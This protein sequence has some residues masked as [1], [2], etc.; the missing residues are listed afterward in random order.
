MDYGKSE[1]IER[2]CSELKEAMERHLCDGFNLYCARDYKN[3][4]L[5][6]R[7]LGYRGKDKVCFKVIIE[8][9]R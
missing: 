6:I 7:D 4:V 5:V 3:G 1:V 9:S 2:A 8:E